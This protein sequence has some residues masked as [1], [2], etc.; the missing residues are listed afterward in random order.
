MKFLRIDFTN[1]EPLRISDIGMSKDN[2]TATINFVPGSS[3]RGAIV[4]NLASELKNDTARFERVKKEL[5]SSGTA[6]YNSYLRAGD[7][8]MYPSPM[9]FYESKNEK[10]KEL[11]NVVADGEFSESYK[12]AKLGSYCFTEGDTIIYTSLCKSDSLNIDTGK[13]KIFR[14]DY[15][16]K[17][18]SFTG[19]IAFGD[20]VSEETIILTEDIIRNRTLRFGGGRSAGYGKVRIDS[21]SYLADGD[22][23]YSGLSVT[24]E[25]EVPQTVYMLLLS[26][27]TM[28]SSFGEI[29]GLNP[30]LLEEKAGCMLR[31]RDEIRASTSVIRMSGFNRTLKNRTPEYRLYAAGSVFRLEFHK[32][33]DAEKLRSIEMNGIGV[34][35][36]D[37]YGRVVFYKDYARIK[38]KLAYSDYAG[39]ISESVASDDTGI[40]SADIENNKMIIARGIAYSRVRTAMQEKIYHEKLDKGSASNSQTGVFRSVCQKYR[41]SYSEAESAIRELIKHIREKEATAKK[42]SGSHGSQKSL[43]LKIENILDADVFT[44]LGVDTKICGYDISRLIDEKNQGMLKIELLERLMKKDNRTGGVK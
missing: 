11:Q 12:R 22:Y 38:H 13:K 35:R 3:L 21:L 42:H 39:N 27:M 34:G 41:Y 36:N 44:C 30:E 15:I 23:P 37:G 14:T 4:N 16:N 43:L 2:E 33:P 7:R 24:N 17:G 10:V 5:L 25:P 8:Q 18:Y 31:N 9:G 19:Y 28:R 29:T 20:N 26:P 6:F 32:A 40:R 1:T